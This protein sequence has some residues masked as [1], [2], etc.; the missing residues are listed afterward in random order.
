MTRIKIKTSIA[1]AVM[2]SEDIPTDRQT[3]RQTIGTGFGWKDRTGQDRTS[4]M[5]MAVTSGK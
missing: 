2:T 5:A 3:D 1:T 4:W